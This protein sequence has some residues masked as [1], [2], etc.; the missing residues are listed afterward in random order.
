MDQIH[1]HFQHSG[2]PGGIGT[3]ELPDGSSIPGDNVGFAA[4]LVHIVGL[5]GKVGVFLG[6]FFSGHLQTHF[7]GVLAVFRAENTVHVAIRFAAV[8]VVLIVLPQ[9]DG[10]AAEPPGEQH[11]ALQ[12]GIALVHQCLQTEQLRVGVAGSCRVGFHLLRRIQFCLTL[13]PGDSFPIRERLCTGVSLPV[14]SRGFHRRV[15]LG[16]QTAAGFIMDMGA[17]GHGGIAAFGMGVFPGFLQRTG[18]FQT[19]AVLAADVGAAA[20]RGVR[21]EFPGLFRY[22]PAGQFRI[23]AGL[24][25]HTGTAGRPCDHR[26]KQNRQD[27]MAQLV[28]KSLL[29]DKKGS[30]PLLKLRGSAALDGLLALCYFK[31]SF[32]VKILYGLCKIDLNLRHI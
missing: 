19:D 15:L 23:T 13:F 5:D 2:V 28:H 8:G 14:R 30:R 21:R 17:F 9:Q 11:G 7:D 26:R 24:G 12:R 18:Q 25:I 32:R 4:L 16:G 3:R 27:S 29:A 1:R 10:A 6:K 22:S 31:F 20:I